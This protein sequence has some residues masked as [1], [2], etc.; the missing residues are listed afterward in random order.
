MSIEFRESLGCAL[1]SWILAKRHSRAFK[2]IALSTI[3]ALHSAIII[4]TNSRIVAR[5]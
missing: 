2:C 4:Q 5:V 1:L 3:M